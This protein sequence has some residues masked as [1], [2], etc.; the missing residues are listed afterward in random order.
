LFVGKASYI[1]C[2]H[3]RIFDTYRLVYGIFHI[4]CHINPRRPH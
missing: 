4:T 1:V 2:Y 3:I